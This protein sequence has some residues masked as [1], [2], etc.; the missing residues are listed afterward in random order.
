M[1]GNFM[2]GNF[3]KI[4]SNRTLTGPGTFLGHSGTPAVGCTFKGAIGFLYPLDDGFIYVHEPPMHIQFEEISNVN[5]ARDGGSTKSF[6]FEVELKS[7]TDHT[8]SSIEKEEYA[9]L[10]DFIVSKKITVKNSGKMTSNYADDFGDSDKA[11]VK[12][13]TKLSQQTK[14]S[15]SFRVTRTSLT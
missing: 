4:I 1:N 9:K 14:K 2:N 12:E 8:F 5:F 7:G 10:Y 11:R 13:E 6:D 15:S 3:M